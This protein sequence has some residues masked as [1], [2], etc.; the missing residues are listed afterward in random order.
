[1]LNLLKPKVWKSNATG[2]FTFEVFTAAPEMT[3]PVPDTP[4]DGAG[5]CGNN[6]L[7]VHN[8]RRRSEAK[9][10]TPDVGLDSDRTHLSP[11]NKHAGRKLVVKAYNGPSLAHRQN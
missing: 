10:R 5:T 7:T 9:A 11:T 2:L 6:H 8:S 4:R 3:N 1:M